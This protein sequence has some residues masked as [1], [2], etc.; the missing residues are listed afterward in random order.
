MQGAHLMGPELINLC[1]L[2][3]MIYE[4]IAIYYILCNFYPNITGYRTTDE[5][6]KLFVMY[7][8]DQDM[9][10]Y[11]LCMDEEVGGNGTRSISR[12]T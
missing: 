11:I 4:N 5:M 8:F 10:T 1:L 2:V 9:D 6:C 3:H 12:G 7:F